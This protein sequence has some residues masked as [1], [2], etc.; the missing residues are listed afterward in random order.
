MIYHGDKFDIDIIFFVVLYLINNL[1]TKTTVD[2]LDG[3]GW[4]SSNLRNSLLVERNTT[5][6]RFGV[7]GLLE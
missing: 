2:N 5:R 4:L 6:S 7:A 3:I 1:H